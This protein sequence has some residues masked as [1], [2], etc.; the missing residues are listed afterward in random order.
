MHHMPISLTT[1][2]VPLQGGD[3]LSKVFTL[4]LLDVQNYKE[5]FVM[6]QELLIGG[7]HYF[8]FWKQMKSVKT[9]AH[10]GFLHVS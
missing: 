6:A 1:C 4:K 8:W 9:F 5:H 3:H 10:K 7:S 2:N